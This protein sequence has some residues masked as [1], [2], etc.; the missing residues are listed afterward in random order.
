MKLLHR[1]RIDTAVPDGVTAA[2]GVEGA[3]V[4]RARRAARARDFLGFTLIELLATMAV[5]V[6]LCTIAATQLSSSASN[7][8]AYTAQSE[9]VASLALARSEAMRRG[10]PVV[11][12]AA[13]PAMGN[14]FGG[15]WTV[16]ADANGNG[17]MDSAD[18]VLRTHEAMP[19]SALTITGSVTAITYNTMGFLQPAGAVNLKICAK[20]YAK[21]GY[22]IAIQPNGM[23]DVDPQAACP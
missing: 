7:N 16:W 14:Q 9:L 2:G 15:G 3:L 4:H 20:S 10:I 21:T 22:A 12:T 5:L 11:V 18:P 1:H 17:V 19:S 23:S 6:I 13:A 8:R